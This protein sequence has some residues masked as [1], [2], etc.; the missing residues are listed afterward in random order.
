[1]TL[2]ATLV[3][4]IAQRC[5]AYGQSLILDATDDLGTPEPGALPSPGPDPAAV[6]DGHLPDP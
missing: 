3:D 5:R 4:G 2:L 6:V 1:M